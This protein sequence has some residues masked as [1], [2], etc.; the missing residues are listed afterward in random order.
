MT[1][2]E[3]FAGY[4]RSTAFSMSLSANMTN[5]ILRNVAMERAVDIMGDLATRYDWYRPYTPYGI[6]GDLMLDNTDQALIRRGLFEVTKASVYVAQRP[7]EW[8]CLDD[9]MRE[10]C[11]PTRA[12]HLVAEL[13]I[14]AGFEP[15]DPAKWVAPLCLHPDDRIPLAFDGDSPPRPPDRREAVLVDHPEDRRYMRFLRLDPVEAQL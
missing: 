15:K 9:D 14:E 8:R 5:R 4:T 2:N 13:L 6:F 7:S 11:V 1:T 12:G 3:A 10:M